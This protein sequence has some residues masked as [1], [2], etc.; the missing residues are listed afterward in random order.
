M[1]GVCLTRHALFVPEKRRQPSHIYDKNLLMTT[2]PRR[3]LIESRC[4]TLQLRQ[5]TVQHSTKDARKRRGY[6]Q[7]QFY[8]LCVHAYH[9]APQC[10]AYPSS[11]GMQQKLLHT[12][13][14]YNKNEAKKLQDQ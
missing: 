1:G 14:D 8:N 4:T 12:W 7:K 13:L 3:R 11:D 6:G 9:I 2:E 5:H 10:S